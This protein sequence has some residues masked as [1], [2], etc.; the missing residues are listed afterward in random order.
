MLPHELLWIWANGVECA[1]LKPTPE[2]QIYSAVAAAPYYAPKLANVEVKTD[3]TV[4][5]VISA[6]PLTANQWASKYLGDGEGK[7]AS[8]EVKPTPTIDKQ[9]NKTIQLTYEVEGSPSPLPSDLPVTPDTDTA[10]E[11]DE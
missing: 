1:G 11:A 7:P 5:A 10:D 3:S 8:I 2:Q 4:R 9:N 6:A